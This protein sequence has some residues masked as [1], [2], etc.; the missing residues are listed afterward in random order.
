MPIHS[1]ALASALA[2]AATC[3]AAAAQSGRSVPIQ[4]D[5][6]QYD[7]VER[8]LGERGPDGPDAGGPVQSDPTGVAG[9]MG[10][11]GGYGGSVNSY[12]PLPQGAPG[13]DIR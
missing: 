5:L 9:F 3:G 8:R 7:R 10:P 6:R 11:P 12:D 13:A 1:L 4:D 2:L